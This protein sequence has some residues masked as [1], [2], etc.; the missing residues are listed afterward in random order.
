MTETISIKT[1]FSIIKRHVL[2][3]LSSA[4]IGMLSAG[5]ALLF[6]ITPMYEAKTQILVTQSA[7]AAGVN[8]LQT[9]EVQANIQL[10]NTYTALLT[11]PRILDDVATKLGNGYT[12]G[13]LMGKITV[14]SQ[15][16]SQVINVSVQDEDPAQAAIIANAVTDSFIKITPDVMNVNNIDVLAKATVA[17]NPKPVSPSATILIAGGAVAGTFIGFVIMIIRVI[18]NTKFK[19]ESDV[20]D[21]LGIPLL[22]NIAKIPEHEE[23]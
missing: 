7:Q 5:V 17:A 10:V 14:G 6:F 8:N 9:S 12:A 23:G 3:L 4:I 13:N 19:E 20:I 1:I 21:E 15:H 11:S 2:L 16:N 18:F 22:G